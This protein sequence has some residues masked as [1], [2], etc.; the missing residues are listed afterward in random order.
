[1][2]FWRPCTSSMLISLLKA[3]LALIHAAVVETV[4]RAV[5]LVPYAK[6]ESAI[7]ARLPAEE[8]KW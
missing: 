2:N 6:T 8:S 4:P 7:G 3:F 5:W 1:M